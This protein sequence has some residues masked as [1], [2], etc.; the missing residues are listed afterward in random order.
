MKYP[1]KILSPADRRLK[2]EGVRIGGPEKAILLWKDMS[3][4]LK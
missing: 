1:H 3:R 2:F 4:D